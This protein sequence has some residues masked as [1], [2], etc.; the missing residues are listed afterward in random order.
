MRWIKYQI[1]CNEIDEELILVD[2]KI[3]YSD[4]NLAIAQTE[5]YN[6]QYQI[7][8]DGKSYEGEPVAVEFGG[9]GAKTAEDARA[10]LGAMQNVAVTAKDAGKFLRV[11]S[12]GKWVAETVPNAEGVSF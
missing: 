3:G 8:D 10:N 1:V 6:G 12:S 2:K 11:S 7:I 4:A 5:A 9:T